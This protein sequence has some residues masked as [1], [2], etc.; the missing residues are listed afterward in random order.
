[1]TKRMTFWL[2]SV[3]LL[4][5]LPMCALAGGGCKDG[6]HD[7]EMIN[8][9]YPT[10]TTDGY[11]VLKCKNCTYT[12]TE[13]TEKAWGCDYEDRGVVPP[14][15][16]V[17]GFHGFVCKNCGDLYQIDIEPLGHDWK[18]DGTI[19]PDCL[20]TGLE[21][22]HCAR[23]GEKW[24]NVIPTIDHDW[25]DS[26]TLEDPTC[27]KEGSMRTVCTV[28]GLSGLRVLNATG[29]NWKNTRIIREATCAAEGKAEA[30][31]RDCGKESTRTLKKL[32]HTYGEWTI[33][34]QATE[35]TK[36][37][38][39]ATCEV[40][41]KKTTEE[42]EYVPGNIAIYTTTGKV[43]LRA[44]VGTNTKRIHQVIKKGTYLG[45]LYESAPDKNGVVWFKIKYKDK[46]CWVMSDFAEAVV[47]TSD[48]TK[49]RLPDAN[50]RELTDYFFKSTAIAVEALGLEE[51][52]VNQV[53]I[54]EWLNDAIYMS[55]A[56]YVEQ[57]VLF[58]EGYSIY[59]VK[60]GD[61]I[62]DAL[63]VLGKKNLVLEEERAD[64]YTYR[65]PALRD[66]LSVEEDGCCGYLNI[67]VDDNYKVEEIR[68]YSDVV[69]HHWT[70]R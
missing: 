33:T 30:K 43:N 19:Y 25:K 50:G 12:K 44:G 61:K 4:V 20:N 46:F 59:G 35:K 13:I 6:D 28:C 34:K 51:E 5:M 58:G 52:A 42:F 65:I 10:C 38:R 26:H 2:C 40:C 69:V 48:M 57:I 3:L 62:K 18:D 60:V 14:T 68:L 63:K 23:C 8:V 47:D 11:Y 16:T 7:L 24:E 45:Q 36:G 17:A 27:T 22:M 64:Q 32:A 54:P 15:C 56:P 70:G 39:T 53:V 49:E 55:G 31:C 37:K 21:K 41:G 1:M 9:K 29:H 67:L 66:A